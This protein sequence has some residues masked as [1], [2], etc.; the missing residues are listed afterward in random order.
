M[1]PEPIVS[2]HIDTS[3]KRPVIRGTGIKVS[4]VAFEYERKAMTPDEIV[5]AHPHLSLADVHSALA[6]YYDNLESIHDD[7]READRLISELQRSH[8]PRR[9]VPRS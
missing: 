2:L 4:Q 3:P 5:E 7:W 1:S 6:F 8:P 9:P